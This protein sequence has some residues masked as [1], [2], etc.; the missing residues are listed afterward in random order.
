MLHRCVA[1]FASCRAM[2]SNVAT[3]QHVEVLV[4]GGGPSGILLSLLLSGY[5]GYAKPAQHPDPDVAK[6]LQSVDFA[7]PVTEWELAKVA[8]GL[9]GRANNEICVLLDQLHLPSAESLRDYPSL[10]EMRREP[11]DARSHVVVTQTVGGMWEAMN[12]TWATLSPGSWMQLPGWTLDAFLSSTGRVA[13]SQDRLERSIVAD[14]YKAYVSHFDL[15]NSF[16][17]GSRVEKVA[18]RDGGGWSVE[19][20]TS[21]GQRTIHADNVVLAGGS[22]SLPRRLSIPGEDLPFVSHRSKLTGPPAGTTLVVGAGLSAADLIIALLRARKHVI[23]IFRTR[24]DQTKIVDKFGRFSQMYLEYFQLSELMKGKLRSDLYKPWPSSQLVGVDEGGRCSVSQDGRLEY[25][26][27]DEVRVLVGSSP[28]LTFLPEGVV[29]PPRT[30]G[31]LTS[32][33]ENPHEVFVDVDP[34]TFE[35]SPGLFAVGPLRGAN[36]VRFLVGDAFGVVSALERQKNRQGA[37]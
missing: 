5:K 32:G 18:K 31:V 12:G 2:A 25:V 15:S 35:A 14:Y 26:Q 21:D 34:G 27:A 7:L 23:H 37:A 4:V 11:K 28:D 10:L 33:D 6:K 1:V 30:R 16:L 17:P 13:N 9:Q 29:S 8:R 24:A 22:Y 19:V 36:F 20:L 3:C